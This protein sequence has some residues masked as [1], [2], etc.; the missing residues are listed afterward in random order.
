ME[1]VMRITI[2][3]GTTF[4]IS[5]KLGNVPE[6]TELGM[7]HEDTR[8]L[9]HYELL[10]DGQ[11]PVPL[12]AQASDPYAATYFLTETGFSPPQAAGFQPRR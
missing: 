7:Y 12:M 4:L 3:A 10:L 6:G 2:N 11:P 9:S 8:F 1:P 5:D